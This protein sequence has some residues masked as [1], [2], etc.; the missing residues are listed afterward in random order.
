MRDII[1][2][3]GGGTG[4]HLSVARA[5]INELHKRKI[6]II[7]IGSTSGADNNGLKTIQKYHKNTF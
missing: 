6:Q 7:F 3:T 5:I 4:G 2:V 1:V